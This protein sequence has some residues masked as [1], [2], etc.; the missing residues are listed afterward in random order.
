MQQDLQ[1]LLKQNLKDIQLPTEVGLWP[2][3]PGWWI[4]VAG[5]LIVLLLA[6]IK[7]Y[8]HRTQNNYRRL[9][10]VALCKA[11]S[12]WQQDRDPARYLQTA[13]ALLR[14]CVLHVQGKEH[15][16]GLSGKSWTETLNLLAPQVLTDTTQSALIRHCYQ[17]SPNID[18]N[19]VHN[20]LITWIKSHRS[21]TTAIKTGSGSAEIV[22]V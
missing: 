7:I 14:R 15:L 5:L 17:R 9:A 18:V 19:T 22:N 11:H 21:I 10:F 16:V 12:Q 4:L 20:E 8:R 13:N 2:L 3:A 1:E 6:S